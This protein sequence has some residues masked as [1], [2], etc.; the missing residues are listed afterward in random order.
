MAMPSIHHKLSLTPAERLQV[1]PACF[2]VARGS[3]SV[4]SVVLPSVIG[5]RLTTGAAT[6]VSGLP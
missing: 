1:L 5:A 6:L 3:T 2:V 4:G